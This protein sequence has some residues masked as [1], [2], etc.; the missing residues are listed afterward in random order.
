MSWRVFLAV[1]V[2]APILVLAVLVGGWVGVIL[3]AMFAAILG[4][5]CLDDRH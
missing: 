3:V 2:T 5:I 1:L 4:G